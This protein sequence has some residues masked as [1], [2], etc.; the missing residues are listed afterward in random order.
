MSKASQSDGGT[1]VLSIVTYL[2]GY[3][4]L[5]VLYGE[6]VIFVHQNCIADAGVVTVGC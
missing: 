2:F 6:G 4:L 5:V 1:L 3:T